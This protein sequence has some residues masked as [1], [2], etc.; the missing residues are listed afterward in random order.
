M[1]QL[2]SLAGVA[3]VAAIYGAG[4][5]FASQAGRGSV[6]ALW[7]S[8]AV[9][10]AW[11]YGADRRQALG[12]LLAC[13]LVNTIMAAP[14]PGWVVGAA[15]TTAN[16]A[17][18]VVVA[19]LV[20]KT[21]QVWWPTAPFSMIA[22]QLVG[23]LLVIPA[24][25]GLIAAGTAT[26]VTG[27]TL[28]HGLHDWILGHAVGMVAVLPFALTLVSGL[29]WLADPGR[30]A[31]GSPADPAI[32]L[33]DRIGPLLLVAAM[34][35]LDLT[36]FVQPMRWPLVLPLVFA[37]FAA[38]W[39][40]MLI[41]TAL[42]LLIAPIGVML[43]LSGVG[44]IAA[45]L[46]LAAD[47]VQVALIYAGLIGCC[48]LPVVVEQ[49]RRRLEVAR[50]SRSAAL[51]KA[52][53]QRADS[54]IDELRRAAM[55]DALTGL[56][57][58]RAFFDALAVQ[59]A[60]SAPACVAMID[61]DHFKQVNDRL[62]HA[63]GDAVL[64]RFADLARANFRVTDMIG[65]IGG[66]EF[67]VILPDTGIDQACAICQRLVDCLAGAQIMTLLGPVQVTISTGIAVIGNDGDAAMAAADAALYAAK[68]AGR[69][70]LSAQA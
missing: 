15:M 19:L 56:P 47:R 54:L 36:V 59:S 57:N 10:A 40:D 14:G 69:S 17:E 51:F 38:L 35:L 50:L 23:G 67:A 48:T 37:V 46:P 42:P 6:P 3:V 70:R 9:L 49:A 65:R 8:G 55:T 29:R 26:W 22:A 11:L 41:A 53:A 13:A 20:R 52:Q 45:G 18:A 58:R 34:A 44:P 5:V 62:G 24:G 27:A 43:T 25:T 30:Y 32:V 21:R 16:L 39:T 61:I 4:L 28:M 31:K 1:R 12:A 2:R 66:E 7:I 33:V 68:R 63:A 60:K 64:R